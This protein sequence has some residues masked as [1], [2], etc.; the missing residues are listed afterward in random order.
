MGKESEYD[1]KLQNVI[2]FRAKVAGVSHTF[3][4]K[5]KLKEAYQVS[6]ILIIIFRMA[7]T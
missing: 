3:I 7:R 2:S 1:A 6:A 5:T 4:K